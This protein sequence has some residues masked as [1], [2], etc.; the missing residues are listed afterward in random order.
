M[1]YF[2]DTN[3]YRNLVRNLSIQEVLELAIN[4]KSE[5]KKGN[6]SAGFPITV[7]MELISHL[8]NGDPHFEECFKALIL[9]FEHTKNYNAEKDIYHGTFFPPLNVVLPKYFFNEDGPFLEIYLLVIKLTNDLVQNQDENN[10][11]HFTTQIQAIKEQILFE[12]KE[13]FENLVQYIIS[14]NNGKLDWEY[15]KKNKVA[16]DKWFLDMKTGKAFTFLAEGFMMRAYSLVGIAFERT[17][18]N[19]ESFKKFHEI[20][21]PAIA[22]V[23]IILIQVGHGTKAIA[24]INDHRWNTVTDISM[25]FGALFNSDIKEKIFVTE[26]KK[27]HELFD[28]NN[29]SNRIIK[30]QEF[31]NRFRI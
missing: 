29:M 8:I 6:D 5:E 17:D 13:I 25:M 22:M 27:M 15:F 10:A 7:A 31:K 1:Q 4:I 30:L 20:F 24:D 26:E 19:F 23:S 21:F 9:L 18:K 11:G 12:K 16:R 3:I 2:L 28:L 14:I